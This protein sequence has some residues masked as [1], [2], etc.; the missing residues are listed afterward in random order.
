[1]M[2]HQLPATVPLSIAW[3]KQAQPTETTRAP[4]KQEGTMHVECAEPRF[5]K[6]KEKNHQYRLSVIYGAQS[7]TKLGAEN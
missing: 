7:E 5:S 1:M 6:E 2:V 4:T 3:H